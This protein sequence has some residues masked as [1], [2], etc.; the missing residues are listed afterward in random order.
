MSTPPSTPIYSLSSH[1]HHTVSRVLNEKHML[2]PPPPPHLYSFSCDSNKELALLHE[3]NSHANHSLSCFKW[4]AYVT[5]CIP[6]LPPPALIAI[7][8]TQSLL[9]A[10]WVPPPPPP[11][12]S[13]ATHITQSLLFASWVPPPP[14]QLHLP[15]TS[16]SLSCLPEIVCIWYVSKCKCNI[17]CTCMWTSALSSLSGE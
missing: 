10:S 14:P 2:P 12:A 5:S 9:F 8:I 11:P 17:L 6:P 15:L 16:H 13:F 1:L 3:Y 4:R 7:H